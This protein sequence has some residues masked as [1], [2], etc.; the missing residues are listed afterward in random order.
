MLAVEDNASFEA[1][2][3]EVANPKKKVQAVRVRDLN[4]GEI[5]RKRAWPNL[6]LKEGPKAWKGAQDTNVM[7]FIAN[8]LRRSFYGDSAS[9]HGAIKQRFIIEKKQHG[10]PVVVVIVPPKTVEVED[11]LGLK[12]GCR[13]ASSHV[14]K[15]FRPEKSVA[16]G[17]GASCILLEND[18][19]LRVMEE[20]VVASLQVLESMEVKACR[21][22]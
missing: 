16:G 9:A 10:G 12:A 8:Q 6:S 13:L 19:V 21:N 14:Y 11:A 15:E 1:L 22:D 17:D 7:V 5:S 18:S 2:G 3:C 20:C 4:R